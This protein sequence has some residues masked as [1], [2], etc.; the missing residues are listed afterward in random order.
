MA[1]YEENIFTKIIRKE[2]PSQVVF[3]NEKI[4]AIRDVNPQAPTHLLLLPKKEITSL[5]TATPTEKELLGEL[6]LEA[7]ALAKRLGVDASGYR[8][9]IN[10]GHDGGQSVPHLHV[11][12]LA[13]RFLLWPPG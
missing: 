3:E 7:A 12:L 6:L 9:V 5:A 13:G 10:T 1:G 4:L 8:L 2:I 11:H